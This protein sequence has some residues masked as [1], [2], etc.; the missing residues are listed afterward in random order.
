MSILYILVEM[1]LYENDKIHGIPEGVSYGQHDRVDELNNRITMRNVPDSPLEP[2]FDIRPVSTKYSHFPI[3]DR[4]PVLKEQPRVY[5]NH[6]LRNNF[7]PGNDKAP[8]S[9]YFSN[10]DLET[11][12]RNQN[13]ALQHGAPQGVYIPTSESELYKVHVVSRPEPQPHSGLFSQ[14]TFSNEIHPNLQNSQIGSD[15]FFN[16]TR[17]QLRNTM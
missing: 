1:E 5:P 2:N 11:N 16:H 12:L 17:T 3:M 8:V 6:R 4:Q 13:F 7:N 9:G 15:K 14:Q 10:V